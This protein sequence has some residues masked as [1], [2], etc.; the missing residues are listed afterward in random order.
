MLFSI[1]ERWCDMTTHDDSGADNPVDGGNT[2]PVGQENTGDLVPR[3]HAQK[4]LHEKKQ[5]DREVAELKAQLDLLNSEKKAAEEAKLVEEKRW[6]E[7]A[8][9]KEQELKKKEDELRKRDEV[10]EAQ[11]AERAAEKKK[12]ETLE[13]L[14]AKFKKPQYEKFLDIDQVPDDLEE[15]KRWIAAFKQE[16]AELLVVNNVTPPPGTAPRSNS[17]LPPKKPTSIDE[18]ARAAAVYAA[19]M[20]QNSGS[21]PKPKPQSTG[22]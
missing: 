14:G 1:D 20:A 5:R 19:Q 21:R 18:L 7:L 8:Q 17:S 13:L 22:E 3:S 9:R 6:Q 10:L 12:Q 4:I 16:N 11:K 2:D 15:R